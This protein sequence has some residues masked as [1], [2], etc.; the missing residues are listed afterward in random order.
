MIIR[1]IQDLVRLKQAYQTVFK[2]SG[3]SEIVLRHLIKLGCVNRTTF[4]PGDP[5]KTMMNEGARRLVLEVLNLIHGDTD[6]VMNRINQTYREE[7]E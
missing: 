4:C 7:K 2:N 1:N 6:A 3:D 5:N